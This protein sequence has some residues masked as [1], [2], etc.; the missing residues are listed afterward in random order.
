MLNARRLR[1][2]EDGR[3]HR[4]LRA[5]RT[6]RRQGACR[7]RWTAA[8]WRAR[9]SM[10]SR[11]SRPAEYA[12]FGAGHRCRDAAYRRIDRR[13]AGNRRRA[14]C[15]ADGR[16]PEE[17][18][19]DQRGQHARACRRSSTARLDRMSTLAERLGNFAAISAT[20]N[21]Q[22]VRLYYF[23]KIAE[24]NTH[25]LRNAGL[26][27]VLSRSTRTQRQRGERDADR[28][29]ARLDRGGAAR[30]ASART[31]IRSASSWKP[32]PGISSVEGAVVLDKPRLLQVDGIYCEATL[33][34]YLMYRRTRTCP[35]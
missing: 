23:G 7:A 1:A 18:R 6:G 24:N 3:A 2:D 32:T 4:Q 31:S 35:A 16:V 14:D 5:R 17:R 33:D 27:G 28:G 13:S 19:G 9:R 22:T 26:A 21:P 29:T 34:G 11:R 12:L 15:R 30:A 10:C 8:R 25:L 20:G